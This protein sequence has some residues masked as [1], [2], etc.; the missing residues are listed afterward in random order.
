MFENDLRHLYGFISA[1]KI[2]LFFWWG[3]NLERQMG[4]LFVTT[5]AEDKTMS[6]MEKETEEAKIN[7][8]F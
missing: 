7:N 3:G 2:I 6:E 1:G 8:Y 4:M 5:R